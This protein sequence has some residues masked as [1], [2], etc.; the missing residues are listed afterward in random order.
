MNIRKS[1]PVLLIFLSK[2]KLY[3]SFAYDIYFLKMNYLYI[4]INNWELYSIDMK[5]YSWQD[6]TKKCNY[7]K[8]FLMET[9][10]KYV[11][12]YSEKTMNNRMK[13]RPVDESGRS[14][15]RV[16]LSSCLWEYLTTNLWHKGYISYWLSHH[17]FILS[18][19]LILLQHIEEKKKCRSYMSYPQL[20][21]ILSIW[22][23][24]KKVPALL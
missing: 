21:N 10:W 17:L 14:L 8:K 3:I 12:N 24:D 9:F 15:P 20:V 11:H 5:Y 18:I 6:S 7:W 2:E 22:G 4:D 19:K 1:A 23:V 16:C 13:K